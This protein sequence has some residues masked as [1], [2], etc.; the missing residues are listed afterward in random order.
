LAKK[1][2]VPRNE[3]EAAVRSG[4]NKVWDLADYFYVTEDFLVRAKKYYKD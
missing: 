2:L 4:H 3:L 1:E